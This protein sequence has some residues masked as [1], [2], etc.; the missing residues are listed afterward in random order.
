MFAPLSSPQHEHSQYLIFF[1]ASRFPRRPQD[2]PLAPEP[3]SAPAAGGSSWGG[4]GGQP[5]LLA[6]LCPMRL[7]TKSLKISQTCAPLL[8]SAPLFLLSKEETLPASVRKA[9]HAG[10]CVC[11]GECVCVREWE[12]LCV[13]VYESVCVCLAQN[14]GREERE[15]KGERERCRKKGGRGVTEGRERSNPT[16]IL[17]LGSLWSPR[18]TPAWMHPHSQPELH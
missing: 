1:K 14:R 2:S 13:C 17:P 12:P 7:R 9:L 10:T 11:A 16:H 8:C 6:P 5:W 4:W 18:P 15:R 3:D